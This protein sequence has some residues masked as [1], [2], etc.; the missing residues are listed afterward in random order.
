MVIE[1]FGF[2][3]CRDRALHQFLDSLVHGSSTLEMS[4]S[5]RGLLTIMAPTECTRSQAP[6]MPNEG[7]QPPLDDA[8]DQK[9]TGQR[10]RG[11]TD[12]R[13]SANLLVRQAG[14]A[15]DETRRQ[16]RRV[17]ARFREVQTDE[18]PG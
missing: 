7:T 14:R 13:R 5:A 16:R 18:S 15:M 11:R 10:W 12:T 4:S 9:G 3:L 2:V 6:S 17:V 1:Y 8:G